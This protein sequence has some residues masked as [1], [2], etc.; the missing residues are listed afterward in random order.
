MYES[1]IEVILKQIRFEYENDIIKAVH[2]TGVLVN[3]EELVKALQYDR[4]QY[5]KGY[6]DGIRD[7]RN[8]YKA[9]TDFPKDY[10][11]GY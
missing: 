9:D 11:Y 2:E 3:K 5:R 4:D 8:E 6:E 10:S 7:A 1:P